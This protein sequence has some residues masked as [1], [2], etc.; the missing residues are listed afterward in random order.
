MTASAASM[1]TDDPR[2]RRRLIVAWALVLLAAAAH[3]VALFIL[4]RPE[5]D[6]LVSANNEDADAVAALERAELRLEVAGRA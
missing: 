1:E 3:R 4:H 5:F 6:A 2:E